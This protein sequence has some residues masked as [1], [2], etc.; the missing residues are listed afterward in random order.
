MAFEFGGGFDDGEMRAPVMAS[1][2]APDP[3]PNVAQS[4]DLAT[5]D[6]IRN[7]FPETWLWTNSTV[8]YIYRLL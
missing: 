8:G 7:V 6:T 5:V 3:E 2:M 1:G 4:S